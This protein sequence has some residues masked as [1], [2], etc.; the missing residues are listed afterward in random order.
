METGIDEFGEVARVIL[1]SVQEDVN[2]E[3]VRA[4]NDK[5]I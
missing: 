4:E 3:V 5:K 1:V 2:K